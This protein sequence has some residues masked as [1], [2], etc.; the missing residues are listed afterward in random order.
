MVC[1]WY[2]HLLRGGGHDS[3]TF[4][5]GR[6]LGLSMIGTK[7]GRVDDLSLQPNFAKNG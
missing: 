7:T 4:N 2:P 5:F 1:V 6:P 3:T